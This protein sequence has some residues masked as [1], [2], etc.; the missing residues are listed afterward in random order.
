MG[1]FLHPPHGRLTQ[2]PGVG[3]RSWPMPCCGKE[4]RQ[5]FLGPVL[6]PTKLVEVGK[7]CRG[8]QIWAFRS[9]M[10]RDRST[11][12]LTSTSGVVCL[13]ISDS[14]PNSPMGQPLIFLSTPCR[15]RRTGICVLSVLQESGLWLGSSDSTL[16][17]A[18]F[19]NASASHANHQ[20]AFS[21]SDVTNHLCEY[22]CVVVSGGM[23]TTGFDMCQ[24][25]INKTL[26]IGIQLHPVK[27]PTA[28]AIFSDF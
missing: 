19:S 13:A 26:G 23:P 8:L 28:V 1:I 18:S 20:Q 25:N 5:D 17:I 10:T 2:N 7:K 21:E 12:S 22:R 4:S 14:F 9:H 6:A 11:V 16:D 3:T 15:S 24:I 27:H